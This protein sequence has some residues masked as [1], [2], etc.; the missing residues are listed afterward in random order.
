MVARIPAKFEDWTPPWA[1]GEFDEEKAA[2][3]IFGL[4]TDKQKLSDSVTT[5]KA[6]K[7]TV[8]EELESTKK[9]LEAAQAKGDNSGE[10]TKLQDK[11]KGLEGDLAKAT[12]RNL[13]VEV[14][15]EKK[16]PLAQAKRLAGSTK[17]ELEADADEFLKDF[18]PQAGG[19]HEQDEDE[20]DRLSSAPR[21]S[22]PGDH[23]RQDTTAFDIS[24]AVASIPR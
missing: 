22:T 1:D 19:E 4:S 9:D 24:K 2:K 10:I 7:A 23:T 5:V 12:T 8:V 6:E 20:T 17:E 21:L 15:I 14:A 3:L 11:V 16:I 13:Q 18:S